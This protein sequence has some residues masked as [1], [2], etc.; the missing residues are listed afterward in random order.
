MKKPLVIVAVIAIAWL[1]IWNNNTA[2]SKVCS[3]V[4]AVQHQF[5]SKCMKASA[6]SVFE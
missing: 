2:F 4:S 6:L 5:P 1:F 3:S